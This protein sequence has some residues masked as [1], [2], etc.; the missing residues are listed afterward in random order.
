MIDH[1]LTKGGETCMMEPASG[2]PKTHRS[3]GVVVEA[4]PPDSKR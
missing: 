4:E 1:K 3:G 2:A